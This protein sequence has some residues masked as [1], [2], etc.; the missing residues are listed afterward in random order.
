[1]YIF[2]LDN[3]F[4][5]DIIDI[6]VNSFIYSCFC[7]L[8]L[9]PAVDLDALALIASDVNFLVSILNV[10]KYDKNTPTYYLFSPY[11]ASKDWVTIDPKVITCHIKHR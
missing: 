1:M 2:N 9:G 5:L 3:F 10:S 6:I 7:D 8:L 11:Y 4:Y